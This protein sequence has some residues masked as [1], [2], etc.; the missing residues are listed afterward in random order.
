MNKS[1]EEIINFITKK[2]F[3]EKLMMEERVRVADKDK[4]VVRDVLKELFHTSS[5]SDDEDAVMNYFM[6]FGNKLIA[7][8]R[9][10]KKDY[11][12][13]AY[14]GRKVIETG[15]KVMSDIVQI[16]VPLEFYQTVSKKQDD[17]LDFA[18]DYEPIKAFFAGEQKNIFDKALLFLEK[19]DD[20]KTYIVNV[21]LESVVDAIR[22]IVRKEKPF[23]DIHKLPELLKEFSDVYMNILD[24]QLAP[25]MDSVEESQKR[26]FEVLNTKEY[27]KQKNL[28]YFTMFGEIEEA[29]K[30]CTNISVLRSYA[31]RAEALK[32]RLLNEMDK[33]DRDIAMHKAEEIRKAL[34]AQAAQNGKVGK[35]QIEVEVK[36]EVKVK[37]TK[38]V[39]VKSM[40]KT[41]SWRIET[42]ED[43]DRYIEELRT[44]LMNELETDTIVNIEF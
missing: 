44:R 6:N 20:S 19:Y 28:T 1:A 37:K 3:V 40:T 18:E 21:K 39:P 35:E 4:K 10:L 34:E 32:I 22:T 12:R 27:K 13:I 5:P 9:V 17:L 16:Q 23:V 8:L 43:V 26:V 24:E 11:E 29:A 31:D 7:E 25:V 2:S 30:A 36:K 38:N 42:R 14:P 41:A 33:M 15:I